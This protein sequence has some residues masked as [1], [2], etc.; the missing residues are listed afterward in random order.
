MV[1]FFEHIHN[2]LKDLVC[3]MN[4]LCDAISMCARGRNQVSYLDAKPYATPQR[5]SHRWFGMNQYIEARMEG[6]KL[7]KEVAHTG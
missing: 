6:S 4:Q 2:D 1:D 7:A 3:L 5:S